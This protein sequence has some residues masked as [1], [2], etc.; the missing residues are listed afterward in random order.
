MPEPRLTPGSV[1]IRVE[2]NGLCASDLHNYLHPAMPDEYLHPVL[3]THG[4][5]VQGHE[6]SGRIVEAAS[7]VEGLP[8]GAV[9]VVEPLVFDGTCAACRR[10]AYNLCENFGF[11]G[12]M[13]GAGGLAEYAVVPADRVHRMP[14]GISPTVAALVEPMAVAWH[15]VRR[16][17]LVPGESVLI[18]GAGPVGLELL[19][20]A[21]AWS[22]GHIT[23][24]EISETR[25][26]QA[27]D[28]G[29]DLVLDPTE[30]DVVSKVRARAP[31]GVDMAFEASGAGTPALLTMIGSLRK[32]GRAVT[33]SQGR[34]VEFDPTVL[35]LAEIDLTGSFGYDGP[36]FPAV[37]ES[38]RIGNLSPKPLITDRVSLEEA[39]E[40]GYE[41]L[42]AHGDRHVKILVHP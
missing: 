33:V 20:V 29:A 3:R 40:R 8:E 6:F 12:L 7:D 37:I 35:M 15:A 23:V 31:G 24:S 1:K 21:R 19:M 11:I 38:I 16:A 13:G 14:E 27:V 5:H 17:G 26:R 39:R 25:R 10:G 42:L 22:A 36:D 34:P 41:E 9:V 4:P 30:V 2:W 18:V 32:G 28:F